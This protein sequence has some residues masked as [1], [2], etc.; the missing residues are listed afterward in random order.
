MAQTARY[1]CFTINDG[2]CFP[3]D[4]SKMNYLVY[5]KERGEETKHEHIQGYLQ[6]NRVQRLSYVK[7]LHATAHWEMSKGTPEQAR[8]YCMKEDTR[9]EGPW[10]FGEM[11][12]Q[13]QRT[14]LE[15]VISMIKEKRPREDYLFTTAYVKFHR[16]LDHIRYLSTEP[17]QHSDVRGIWVYGPPG[18][19][20]SHQV[21]TKHPIIFIKGQNKWFDGYNDEEAILI[22]D[23][24]RSGSCLGHHLKLWT[25]KWSCTGEIKGGTIQLLHKVFYITSNYTIDEIFYEDSQLV[26]ALKRRFTIYH[27]PFPT[28]GQ[29]L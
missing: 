25:D 6:L 24:D 8:D 7:K 3:Y 28:I 20:K 21:R 23:F 19:G 4:E 13:G 17:Y 10:Q 18:V 15:S 29:V 5:Q 2:D 11:K 9:V 1:W 27:I 26:A 12:T 14:D 16:G 22:D